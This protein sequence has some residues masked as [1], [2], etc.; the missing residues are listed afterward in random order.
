[1]QAIIYDLVKAAYLY[2]QE[3]ANKGD[4]HW[5]HVIDNFLAGKQ[6]LQVFGEIV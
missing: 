2:A 1:M 3:Q 4:S 5:E 6:T